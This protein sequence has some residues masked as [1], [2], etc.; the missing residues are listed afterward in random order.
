M[1]LDIMTGAISI[2]AR[3]DDEGIAAFKG[4]FQ[5]LN[6]LLVEVGQSPHDEPQVLDPAD[7]FEAQMWGYS[8]LH[9]LRRVAAY[10]ALEGRLPASDRVDEA[11]EDPVLMRL[12]ADH[13]QYL[14]RPKSGFLSLLRKS[15]PKPQFEHL[16]LHSDAE[17]VYLPRELSD[18][19]FDPAEPRREGLG[20]MVGSSLSLLS[21]CRQISTALALPGDIDP[22]CDEVDENADSLPLE[23]E[24]W[25][26]LGITT[27]VLTRLL[28]ACEMSQR[29]GAAV[30]FT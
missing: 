21:E 8:G 28:R 16:M 1:G 20:C 17:G 13:G 23:G 12:Y 11:S 18:V 26:R 25:Q 3:G 9:H 29:T 5:S 24:P 27:F 22:E 14:D 19:I 30:V 7:T 15:R 10:L 6:E 4:L 2:L